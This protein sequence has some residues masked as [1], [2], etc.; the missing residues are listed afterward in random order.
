MT[1]EFLSEQRGRDMTGKQPHFGVTVPQI[2][3]SWM[4]A[5]AAA[6]ARQLGK[7]I[8]TANNIAG[9]A[10]HNRILPTNSTC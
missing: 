8:A 1:G 6:A 10:V 7:V 3:H 2:K 5:D 4:A 9:G